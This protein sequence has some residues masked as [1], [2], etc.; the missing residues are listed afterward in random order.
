MFV[1][2]ILKFNFIEDG[3]VILLVRLVAEAYCIGTSSCSRFIDDISV[4]LPHNQGPY[5][6]VHFTLFL[7]YVTRMISNL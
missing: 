3:T 1:G 7:C 4:V 5:Q 2:F 6:Y